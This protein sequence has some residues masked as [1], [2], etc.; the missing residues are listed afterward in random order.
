MSCPAT[1]DPAAIR[2]RLRSLVDASGL[3]QA[4]VGEAAGM[5]AAHLWQ[6]LSG[7]RAA[8]SAPTVGR[9]L[10]ALDLPWAALDP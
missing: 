10:A 8:P 4:E 3:T 9:I 5:S 2:A 6:V 1:H 7:K